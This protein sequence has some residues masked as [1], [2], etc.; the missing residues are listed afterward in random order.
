MKR[1]NRFF[2][3]FCTMAVLSIFVGVFL[4]PTFA[5]VAIP[6]GFGALLVASFIGERKG[7]VVREDDLR[8]EIYQVVGEGSLNTGDKVLF[9]RDKNSKLIAVRHVLSKFLL[10]GRQDGGRQ[11]AQFLV[12]ASMAFS[13]KETSGGKGLEIE[14]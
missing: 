6:S 7:L 10:R 8:K 5:L 2:L 12:P 4:T 9:L 3:F 1:E 13:Y 11:D 14:S